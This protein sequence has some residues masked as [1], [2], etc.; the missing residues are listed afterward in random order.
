MGTVNKDWVKYPVW[1]GKDDADAADQ[2]AEFAERLGRLGIE[3]IGVLDQPP[4]DEWEL[5]GTK[6]R[7]SAASIYPGVFV[8][9]NPSA[10]GLVDIYYEIPLKNTACQTVR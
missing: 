8:I 3:M 4:E 6:K 5:F 7:M 10:R 9:R 2:L 1:F